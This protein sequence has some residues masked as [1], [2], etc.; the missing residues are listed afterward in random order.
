MGFRKAD[1]D[2]LSSILHVIHSAKQTLKEAGIDQW[3]GEYPNEEVILADIKKDHAYVWELDI[4]EEPG[5]DNSGINQTMQNTRKIIAYVVL[6]R[7]LE[8]DYEQIRNGSWL[9]QGDAYVVVHR[10]AIDSNYRGEGYGGQI[11][12]KICEL[13]E[14]ESKSVR[15]DTHADNRAMQRTLESCGFE[16]CGEVLLRGIEARLAYERI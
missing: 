5:V 2:D 16:Y 1:S 4:T 15:V 3:Q 13:A 14:A 7:D 9:S 11:L 12:R 8:T 10:L 6:S